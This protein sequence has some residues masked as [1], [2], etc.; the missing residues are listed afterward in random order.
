MRRLLFPKP[1]IYFIQIVLKYNIYYFIIAENNRKAVCEVVIISKARQYNTK[2]LYFSD[3]LKKNI[4]KIPDYSLTIVEAPMGY[5]KTTALREHLM[6]KD[7]NAVWQKIYDNSANGFWNGFCRM[8][9]ELDEGASRGLTN[10]GFPNDILSMQNA[11]DI[12]CGIQFDGKIILVIDDYHMA[13]NDEIDRFISF[14]VTNEVPNIS[15]AISTRYMSF[16]M[17]D[18]LKLKGYL[19]HITKESFELKSMEIQE[20]YQLCGIY[21]KEGEADKLY[22]FTE[23]WISALY[24]LM[25]NFIEEGNFTA[26]DNIYSLVE[27]SVYASFSG[28]VKDF[29]LTLSIFDSFTLGQATHMWK[30]ENTVELIAEIINKNAFVIYDRR[31]ETY[32]M[33]N[34]LTNFLKSA[35]DNKPRNFKQDIYSNAASWYIK[36]EDYFMAM[37]YCFISEDFD[38]LLKVI[39]IDKANSINS[40]HKDIFIKYFEICPDKYKKGHPLALLVYAMCMFTFNEAERF[41]EVCTE[42]NSN[43]E[44]DEKLD[45][46]IKNQLLGEYMLLLSFTEYNDIGKML[47]YLKKAGELL[48]GASELIDTRGAWT[49]GSPSVLYMF[50]REGGMLE[51]EVKDMVEAMPYYCRLTNNHGEG[52]EYVMMAEWHFNKGNFE[53]SEIILHKALAAAKEQ[54]QSGP[55]IC[56]MFLM[57]RLALIKG[58]SSGVLDILKKMREE[59]NS[60]KLYLF[61]HTLDMCEA[62]IYSYLNQKSKIPIWILNGELESTRLLFPSIGFLNIVYGRVLLIN[63][64]YLKL[65]GSSDNQLGIASVFP[66]M[67]SYIYTYI[68]LAC[69]KRRIKRDMEAIGDLKRALD[70]AMP[71][72]LFMPFVENC[73]YIVYLLEE[74][75]KEPLYNDGIELILKLYEEYR[76][77]VKLIADELS[78]IKN[79]KLSEREE[80]IARLAA[81]G[82]SNKEIGEMLFISQNTVKTQ[83]KSVFEKL[84]I[85]SRSLLSQYL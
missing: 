85:N 4:L 10:L 63:G 65:I 32:Q 47:E 38:T 44:S 76:V 48:K 9:G 80:E 66:N 26:A 34:I 15:I 6:N 19:H 71:D 78:A 42:F 27:K 49:F 53:D 72:S 45:N 84:N 17:L 1:S 8:F 7:V 33:H 35:L 12:I 82:L 81:E 79:P 28:E 46:D 3:N 52:A 51:K 83:L 40:E 29:L 2:A 75:K 59:I 64:E 68:Y 62:Y 56:A 36:N 22:S 54:I 20:Y 13:E 58:D 73:D 67:L 11:L 21:L 5:G 41:R 16:P 30:N 31:T 69:A 57:A 61:M 43:I 50:Y 39:E 24:L 25:L 14:F 18:E 60:N 74:L 77:S 23:G 70:I 37:H 55:Y